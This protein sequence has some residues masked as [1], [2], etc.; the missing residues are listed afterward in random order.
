LLCV[1]N[2]G[3]SSSV[4]SRKRRPCV[5]IKSA[6]ADE[7]LNRF[8]SWRLNSVKKREFCEKRLKD[9]HEF[10]E[11]R[12][13]E[14]CNFLYVF[15][16]AL[17]VN[18][19]VCLSAEGRTELLFLIFTVPLRCEFRESRH[20]EGRSVLMRC[21]NPRGQEAAARFQPRA[22]KKEQ[23]FCVGEC[24]IDFRFVFAF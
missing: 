11:N 10:R 3:F 23:A 2:I 19:T 1:Q 6:C 24:T 16:S 13:Y 5:R 20:K 4:V 18:A 22:T 9:S 7:R 15:R 12:C 8:T 14:N 17:E 21:V